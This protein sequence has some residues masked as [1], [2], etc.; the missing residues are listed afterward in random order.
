MLNC[1]NKLCKECPNYGAKDSYVLK[2]IGISF[3]ELI[4]NVL[5]G[6]ESD[7]RGKGGFSEIL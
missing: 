4:Q 5:E 1:S 2:Q 6:P 7:T 3:N